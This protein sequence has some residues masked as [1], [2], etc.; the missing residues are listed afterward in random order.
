MFAIFH[1]AHTMGMSYQHD[2]REH[3]VV[4]S[5]TVV[6]AVRYIVF[7]GTAD[8]YDLKSTDHNKM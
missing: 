3:E 6:Y 7:P 8:I 4:R 5:C 2:T 1:G